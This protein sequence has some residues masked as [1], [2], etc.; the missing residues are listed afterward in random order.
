MRAPALRRSTHNI[1]SSHKCSFLSLGL[2]LKAHLCHSQLLLHLAEVFLVGLRVSQC[3]GEVYM[4]VC[5]CTS[6]PVF[7]A[8]GLWTSGHAVLSWAYWQLRAELWL[9]LSEEVM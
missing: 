7:L 1:L 2:L 4:S 8:L 5:M 6:V 9:E 3:V